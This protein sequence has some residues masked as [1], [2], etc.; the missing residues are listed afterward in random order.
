N[1]MLRPDHVVKVLDFGLAKLVEAEN[2]LSVDPEAQTRAL[3]K[4]DPGMVMGTAHYMSPE[5]AR[6]LET[7]ARTDVWSLGVV[8]YEMLT[9]QQPFT[10]ETINHT[11]VAILEKEPPPVSQFRSSYPPELER[12]IKKCL[13]K[14]ADERYSAAKSLLDDLKELKEELA[15]QSKL[16]RSSAPNKRVE[17]ERQIIKAATIAE[18][19]A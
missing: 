9:K 8:L 17:A 2:P 5:Q 1:I 3:V 16:E 13:A 7:D 14:K 11:I 15:F 18:T 6:G 12:I 19:E 10:G 4:T